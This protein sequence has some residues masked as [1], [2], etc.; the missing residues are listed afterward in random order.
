MFAGGFG[1]FGGGTQVNSGDSS[2]GAGFSF[3]GSSP[4]DQSSA[5]NT[6]TGE[7]Y[8]PPKLY[9][10]QSQV[11]NEHYSTVSGLIR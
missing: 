11:E 7:L 4:Q 1:L 8:F 9:M 10:W 5:S 3:G 6:S 2:F